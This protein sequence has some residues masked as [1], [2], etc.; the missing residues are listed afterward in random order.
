MPYVV[1]IGHRDARDTINTATRDTVHLTR[2]DGHET[3]NNRAFR[4]ACRVDCNRV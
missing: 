1:R 3:H 2:R 4:V